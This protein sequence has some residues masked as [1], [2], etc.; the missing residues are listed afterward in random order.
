MKKGADRRALAESIALEEI[1]E[2]VGPVARE[3]L[4]D[5]VLRE[6]SALTDLLPMAVAELTRELTPPE[7]GEEDTI[8]PELRHKAALQV[9]K[10]TIGNSS[11][12]P[13]SL[14]AAPLPLQ[15]IIGSA[16]ESQIEVRPGA[17]ADSTAEPERECLEC[18]QFKTKSEFVGESNRCILCHDKLMA[19]VTEKYGADLVGSVHA[20]DE[21]IPTA[22]PERAEG[23]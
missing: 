19:K 20:S 11:I 10:M 14:E 17:D 4:T 22:L 12:A 18:H 13:P 7:E 5:K 16:M 1:R 9:M 23:T 6:L 15:V 21:R 2:V 3:L 8:D